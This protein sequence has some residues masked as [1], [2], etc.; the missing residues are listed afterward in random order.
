LRL[1]ECCR[2]RVKDID[3][4][5]RQ[6]TIRDGKGEKDRMAPLPVRLEPKLRAQIDSV[7][8]RHERDLARGF[9][10]VLLPYAYARKWPNADRELGWQY[11]FPSSRLS[12]DP[13]GDDGV[14]FRHHRHENLL[15]KHVK[16][17][18]LEAGLTKRVTCH[19]FR[20]SFATHLLESGADIR[21]VQE[22]IGHAA[23]LTR[24]LE[25]SSPAWA[26]YWLRRFRRPP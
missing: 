20:H 11:L 22:L 7:R 4:D 6:L 13:R 24:G 17:A 1:L 14:L 16:R 12:V 23:G 5:R 10:R 21:T 3:F 15:Q 2:L 8:R 26:R 18:A 25:D 19:T 9:G